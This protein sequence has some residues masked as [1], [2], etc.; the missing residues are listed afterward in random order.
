MPSPIHH[1]RQPPRSHDPIA[2][3]LKKFILRLQ[4][5][6]QV[7]PSIDCHRYAKQAVERG[8]ARYVSDDSPTVEATETGRA[9]AA[10]FAAKQ[11][12]E[13]GTKSGAKT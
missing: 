6:G 4:L 11:Q 1:H 7:T 5:R 2:D 9:A 12:T 3:K 10:N 8:W 13:K